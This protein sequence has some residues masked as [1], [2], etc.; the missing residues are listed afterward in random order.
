[1]VSL[2]LSLS[3]RISDT[4][5]YTP[6]PSPIRATWSANLILLDLSPA[7]CWV[8]ITGHGA[9]HYE[10]F[11]HSPVT[12]SPLGPNTLLNTIFSN[13]LSLRFSFNVSDQISHP[14]KTNDKIM[15]LYILRFKFLDSKLEDKIF[16][17][18]WQ[19][20]FPGFKLLLISSWMKFWFVRVVPKYSIFSTLSLACSLII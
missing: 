5:L 3:L 7:K 16:R 15:F 18:Q 13:A 2:S 9:P 11:L 12:S 1:V 8:R 20:T 14:Y 4:I 19:Q 17:T 6:L 10:V